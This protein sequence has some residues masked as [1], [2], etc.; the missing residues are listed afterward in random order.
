MSTQ[1]NSAAL[2]AESGR[3]SDI[4]RQVLVILSL[5]MTIVV[6]GLANALPLN[7]QNYGRDIRSVRCLL[8]AGR[9]CL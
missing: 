8:R 3:G 4:V 6:N 9:L 2:S 7:G 5:A 1:D